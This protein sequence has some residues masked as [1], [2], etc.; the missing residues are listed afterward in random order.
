MSE[1]HY[2]SPEFEVLRVQFPDDVLLVSIPAESDFT[3]PRDT[4]PGSDD[5]QIETF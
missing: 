4:G 3:E 5:F 2:V 1:Q